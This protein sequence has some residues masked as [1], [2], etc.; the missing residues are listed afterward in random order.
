MSASSSASCQC[1][2]VVL[3]VVGPTVCVVRMHE[4]CSGFW[5]RT[6][7][8][9]VGRRAVGLGGAPQEGTRGP[10]SAVHCVSDGRE[11]IYSSLVC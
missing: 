4:T 6:G 9:G 2:I 5:E 11:M 8:G 7:I 3:R 1:A 10:G